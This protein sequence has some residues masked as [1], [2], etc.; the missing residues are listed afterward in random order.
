MLSPIGPSLL[1]FGCSVMGMLV[2]GAILGL[3]DEPELKVNLETSGAA[4]PSGWNPAL[5]PGVLEDPVAEGKLVT[6]VGMLVKVVEMLVDVVG[7]RVT[8]V[9]GKVVTLKGV[10]EVAVKGESGGQADIGVAGNVRRDLGSRYFLFQVSSTFDCCCAGM[11]L[12][13]LAGGRA[14]GKR[15]YQIWTSALLLDVKL[16][17]DRALT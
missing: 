5:V 9:V 11:L 10:V 8:V 6:L 15:L 17:N 4:V 14:W 2:T 13:K 16:G 3:V 1:L 12:G 7:M